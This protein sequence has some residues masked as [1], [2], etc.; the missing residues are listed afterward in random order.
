MTYRMNLPKVF[1]PVE[2][3]RDPTLINPP[4]P[5]PPRHNFAPLQ[6]LTDVQ[7]L[8]DEASD[9]QDCCTCERPGSAGDACGRALR[10]R[11]VLKWTNVI[12]RGAPLCVKWVGPCVKK[13]KRKLEM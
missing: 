6:P 7:R 12:Y 3:Q 1:P 10:S 13:K 8:P 2:R 9:Y 4:A 5:P 11:A